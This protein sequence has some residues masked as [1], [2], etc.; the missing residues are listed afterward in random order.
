MTWYRFTGIAHNL[1]H[2][3]QIILGVA[4]SLL[5]M[6]DLGPKRFDIDSL[7]SKDHFITR[8][9]PLY[10]TIL[11]KAPLVIVAAV[12]LVVWLVTAGG[13]WWADRRRQS[14]EREE[15]DCGE[16][17]SEGLVMSRMSHK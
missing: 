2:L 9:N 5:G 11:D 7:D 4:L 15:G 14:R 10:R 13:L 8:V 1:V 3:P 16:E 17:D 6:L 12:Y